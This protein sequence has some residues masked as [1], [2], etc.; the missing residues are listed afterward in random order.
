M[1]ACICLPKYKKENRKIKLN[2]EISLSTP[3]KKKKEEEKNSI[4]MPVIEEGN[5]VIF[6]RSHF[7]SLAA[8]TAGGS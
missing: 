5:C 6:A 3:Q 4:F 8:A 1:L 7:L 2:S